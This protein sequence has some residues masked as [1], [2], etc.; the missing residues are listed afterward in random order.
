MSVPG[1]GRVEVE[2][3]FDHHME[4]LTRVLK[5]PRLSWPVTAHW[6]KLKTQ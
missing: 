3:D 5:A 1:A 2:F 4:A 6:M